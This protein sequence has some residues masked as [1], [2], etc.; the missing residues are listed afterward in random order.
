MQTT[1]LNELSNKYENLN[2]AQKDVL[3]RSRESNHVLLFE[4]EEKNK[5]I[6]RLKNIIK[7]KSNKLSVV[8]VSYDNTADKVFVRDHELR[9][10]ISENETLRRKLEDVIIAGFFLKI[11]LKGQLLN[12]V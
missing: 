3:E 11:R 12:S 1:H 9:D 5:E 4:L 8:S 10:K 2:L 7:E 6:E